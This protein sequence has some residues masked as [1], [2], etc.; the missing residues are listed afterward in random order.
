LSLMESGGT[1]TGSGTLLV[2]QFRGVASGVTA[3]TFDRASLRG[4]TGAAVEAHFFDG[5]LTVQ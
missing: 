2:I 5:S 4:A 3:L 1:Y